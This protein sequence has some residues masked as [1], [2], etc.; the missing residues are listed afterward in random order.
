[1]AAAEGSG[2]GGGNGSE[3]RA[4]DVREIARLQRT[5]VELLE[6]RL[7]VARVGEESLRSRRRQQTVAMVGV[8]GCVAVVGLLA[9]L[10]VLT[11]VG[12][13]GLTG[14]A[15]LIALGL[16]VVALLLFVVTRSRASRHLNEA[17]DE[18]ERELLL[19]EVDATFESMEERL[20]H[21]DG[22]SEVDDDF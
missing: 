10:P 2:T 15:S 4:E 12:P 13:F 11:G 18:L 9:L 6:L 16:A 19:I 20:R 14:W 3:P 21:N 8:G 1:M 7:D 22:L 17:A 5:K